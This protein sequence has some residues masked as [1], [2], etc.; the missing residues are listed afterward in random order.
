MAPGGAFA[1]VMENGVRA[2]DGELA[3]AAEADGTA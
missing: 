3:G 2:M 1:G